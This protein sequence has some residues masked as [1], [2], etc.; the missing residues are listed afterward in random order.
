MSDSRLIVPSQPMPP[1]TTSVSRACTYAAPNLENKLA[2]SSP[3]NS[4]SEKVMV[5][6]LKN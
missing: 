1:K 3:T 4:V 2:V 6:A 5:G